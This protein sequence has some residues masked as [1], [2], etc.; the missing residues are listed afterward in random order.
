VKNLD[1]AIDWAENGNPTLRKVLRFCLYE[2]NPDIRL[3]NK[4]QELLDKLK[5]LDFME[6]EKLKFPTLSPKPA[7]SSSSNYKKPSVEIPAGN[8]DR[9]QYQDFSEK[10]QSSPSNTF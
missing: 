8:I 4:D 2:D 7:G 9:S 10:I 6:K 5:I 3:F 1:N